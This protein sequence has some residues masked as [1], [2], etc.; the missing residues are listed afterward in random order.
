MVE[1]RI[2][3]VD[4]DNLLAV[5]AGAPCKLDGAATH[6]RADLADLEEIG[7]GTDLLETRGWNDL[8]GGVIETSYS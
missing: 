5:L 6:E 4:D 2:E 1:A 8:A 7:Q 3:Q